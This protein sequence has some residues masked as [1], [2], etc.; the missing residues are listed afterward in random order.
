MGLL[1]SV[2]W[3]SFLMDQP[4]LTTC[5]RSLEVVSE[6]TACLPAVSTLF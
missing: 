3:L 4:H 1:I 6:I 2:H 5:N